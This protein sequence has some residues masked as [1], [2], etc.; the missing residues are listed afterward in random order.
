[1]ADRSSATSDGSPKTARLTFFWVPA[2]VVGVLVLGGVTFRTTFQIE[3]LRQQS[4]V[5]ATLSLA[6]E[7]V[8]RLDKRIIEEDNVG[9]RQGRALDVSG[10]YRGAGFPARRAKRRPCAPSSFSTRRPRRTTSSPSRR[11]PERGARTTRF[12]GFSSQRSTP[13]L[14]LGEPFDELRH[15]HKVYGGQSYLVS[16]WLRTNAARAPYLVVAWHDVPRIVHDVFPRL[17][18]DAARQQSA[19]TSSTRTAASSSARRCAAASSRSGGPS[20]RRS[21]IGGCRSPWPRPRSSAARVERRRVLEMLMVG[22]SCVVVIAGWP[23]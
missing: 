18:A 6:N 7:K 12:A 15:L 4:V 1:M 9:A 5:E 21:T 3:K 10:R 17:F 20:R 8:D 13:D 11:V 22:L 19:S 16:Y 23:W 2:I 14:S